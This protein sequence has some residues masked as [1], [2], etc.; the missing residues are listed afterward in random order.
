MFRWPWQKKQ[1]DEQK[2]P[3]ARDQRLSGIDMQIDMQIDMLKLMS[4]HNV[5]RFDGL[6][7]HMKALVDLHPEAREHEAVLDFAKRLDEY[8]KDGGVMSE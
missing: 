3:P 5:T 2:E 6:E 7:A 1:A 4:K 8:K